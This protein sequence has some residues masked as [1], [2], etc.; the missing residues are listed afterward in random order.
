MR[1][2]LRSRLTVLAGVIAAMAFAP[3]AHAT[4]PGANGRIAFARAG[5]IYTMQPDGHAVRRLTTLADGSSA[6]FESWSPDGRQIVFTKFFPDV[7]AQ[8]WVMAADGSAQRPLLAEAGFYELAPR[9]SPDGKSIVLSRCPVDRPCAIWRMK[10]DGTGLGPLTL[11]DLEVFDI[12]PGFSPDGESITFHSFAREGVIAGVYLMAADGSDVRLITPPALGGCC[13]DWAPDGGRLVFQSHS[14]GSG[15]QHAA[16]W[17]VKPDGTGLKHLTHPGA[18]HD[19]DPSWSPQGNAIAFERLTPDFSSTAV[20]V[21]KRNGGGLK[22]IQDDAEL[23]RWG[24]RP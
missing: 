19:F 12:D 14:T 7:P 16:I 11:F 5:D 24:A 2:R 15:P 13:P 9:F 10:A 4:F 3:P 17:T 1:K 18:Q 22:K 8:L 23:P 21:M 6:F 20:Y